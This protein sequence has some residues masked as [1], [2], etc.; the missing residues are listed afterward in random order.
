MPSLEVH[1]LN[2][3]RDKDIVQ[4]RSVCQAST[5]PWISALHKPMCG[6]TYLKIPALG[7]QEDHKFKA[8]LGCTASWRPACSR[9]AELRSC[10][11]PGSSVTHLYSQHSRSK[12]RWIS[13]NLRLAWSI[14]QVSGQA[15]KLQRNPISKTTTTTTK[16]QNQTK[17]KNKQKPKKDLLSKINK[18]QLTAI[19]VVS[20]IVWYSLNFYKYPF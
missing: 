15:L 14:E 1:F 13:V 3:L 18:V 7:S 17:P 8:T 2:S 6:C 16:N 20:W 4:L 9:S 5:R 11:Q 12:G 10:L 19:S